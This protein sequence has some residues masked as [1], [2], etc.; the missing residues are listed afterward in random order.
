MLTWGPATADKCSAAIEELRY[1]IQKPICREH[2]N[3]VSGCDAHV[4]MRFCLHWRIH[5]D[6][7]QGG[8]VT[9]CFD[10]QTSST[11]ANRGSTPSTL[12]RGALYLSLGWIMSATFIPVSGY[13][14]RALGK[15]GMYGFRQPVFQSFSQIESRPEKIIIF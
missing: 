13:P 7:A 15:P 5:N 14:V 11:G 9:V 10:A 12:P 1:P 6:T 3:R 4:S 8:G 2:G